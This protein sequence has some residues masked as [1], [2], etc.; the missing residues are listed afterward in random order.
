MK[1]SFLVCS[2]IIINLIFSITS[3][4]GKDPV[5]NIFTFDSI[6]YN[7]DTYEWSL[8]EVFLLPVHDKVLIEARIKTLFTNYW[9][10]YLFQAGIVYVWMPG[11]YS[12]LVYG[13]AFDQDG[14]PSH[15]G[16][17]ETTYESER[18]II[19][20]RYKMGFYP[21]NDAYF[22]LANV[23]GAYNFTSL[24]GLQLKYYLGYDSNEIWTHSI[25]AENRF[26]WNKYFSTNLVGT[27]G[28]S[29]D[30]SNIEVPFEVGIIAVV[31]FN[32]KIKLR[33]LFNYVQPTKE[34]WGIQNT[35]SLD[36]SF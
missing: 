14:N 12:E 33:Y 5:R 34:L 8:E 4:F 10:R 36:I 21:E 3:V 24:Y 7:N 22:L 30:D 11:L 25:Q 18:Y 28:V 26:N 19:S 35:L 29:I 27:V 23:G 16:F 2:L 13:V 9:Q 15:E 32:P 17:F 6:V 1:R 31:R 20:G